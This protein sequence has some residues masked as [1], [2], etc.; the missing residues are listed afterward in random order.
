MKRE[1]K[2]AA[3]QFNI[4]LGDIDANVDQVRSAVARCAAQGCQ[5]AVLPEMWSCGFDYRNLPELAK[6]VRGKKVFL[7]IDLD[8]FDPALTGADLLLG[9]GAVRDRPEN[10][11]RNTMHKKIVQFTSAESATMQLW[12]HWVA[13]TQ[14]ACLRKH[15]RLWRLPS[16]ARPPCSFLAGPGPRAGSPFPDSPAGT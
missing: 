10:N 8:G 13:P 4:K 3:V 7:T 14:S 16:S 15:G 6:L 12:S 1:I 5:L 2:A 11:S 9:R